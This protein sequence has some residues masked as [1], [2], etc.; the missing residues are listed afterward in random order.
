MPFHP[1]K[2]GDE[3][4]PSALEY[5][6]ML[7]AGQAYTANTGRV[8]RRNI[9]TDPNIVWVLNTTEDDHDALTVLALDDPSE[10]DWSDKFRERLTFDGVLPDPEY[11]PAHRSRIAVLADQ[12]P[13]GEIG[14]AWIGGQLTMPIDVIDVEHT[15]ARVLDNG[16]LQSGYFGPVRI[17]G[18]PDGST[19]G[20]A[21]AP[22]RVLIDGYD[23]G[24]CLVSGDIAAGTWSGPVASTCI[25]AW[26]SPASGQA[27]PVPSPYDREVRVFHYGP[28]ITGV[29]YVQCRLFNGRIVPDVSYCGT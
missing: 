1:V 25:I 16:K 21:D 14:P 17:L 15:R 11:K 8:V 29:D 12:I 27:T 26:A 9:A 3:F 20:G 23:G 4:S 5:N 13:A 18:K 28:A 10:T 2:A 22:C 24:H 19:G 6:A 7:R